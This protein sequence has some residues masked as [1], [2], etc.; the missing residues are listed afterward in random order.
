MSSKKNKKNKLNK[1]ISL[2]LKVSLRGKGSPGDLI[3]V[4][5]GYSNYLIL[6]DK[7]MIANK[8]NLET[9]EK[10]KEEWLKVDSAKKQEGK[11]AKEKIDQIVIDIVHNTVD[12]FRLY[13]SVSN[14]DI[15]E[16]LAKKGFEIKKE[17]IVMKAIKEV[18]TFN[19]N[20]YTY[21][22]KANITINVKA[23]TVAS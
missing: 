16:Q 23:P 12:G 1:L 15:M 5:K 3:K 10:Q 13:G 7:A 18:G 21:G 4:K 6:S 8:P 9:M 2:V 19:A 17:D 20:I 22:N 14:K 11:V